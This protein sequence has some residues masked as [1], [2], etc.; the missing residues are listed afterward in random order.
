MIIYPAIDLRGGKVVRLREGDPNRQTVFSDDPVST[1]KRWIDMGAPWL[2]IVNLDGAF[3]A[4]NDN[5]TV[6][7][8]IAALSIPIQFGGGLR[9]EADIHDALSRGAARIVLG[10]AAIRSPHLVAAAVKTHGSDSICVALDSRAG[11]VA[12]EGWQ[13]VTELTPEALGRSMFEMGV[14]HAL[15]TDVSRDGNLEG[16]N[17]TATVALGAAT[18]LHVIASGGVNSLDDIEALAAQGV[19]GAVIGMALYEGKIALPD[20]LRVAAKGSQRAG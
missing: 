8:Q 15:Y 12:I 3:S 20:A 11:K 10:T 19:A 14:R 6:L 18:G 16:V 5:L 17:I 4:A 13:S 7:E 1:A 2:H 9:S